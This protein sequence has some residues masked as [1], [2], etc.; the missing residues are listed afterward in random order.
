MDKLIPV[1]IVIGIIIL[2]FIMKQIELNDAVKRIDFTNYYTY[3]FNRCCNVHHIR[4]E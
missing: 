2:G 3:R 1:F 4:L